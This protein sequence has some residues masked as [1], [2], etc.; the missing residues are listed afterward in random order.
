[1][2]CPTSAWSLNCL[3]F[4]LMTWKL[5]FS[6]FSFLVTLPA[7]AGVP[8]NSNGFTVRIQAEVNGIR[9]SDTHV[10]T[11]ANDKVELHTQ[12]FKDGEAVLLDSV[13]ETYKIEFSWYRLVAEDKIYINPDDVDQLSGMSQFIYSGLSSFVPSK[14]SYKAELF[15]RN[16][17]GLIIPRLSHEAMAPYAE[18]HNGKAAG[19]MRWKVIVKLTPKDSQ[20]GVVRITSPDE[21]RLNLEFSKLN[22]ERTKAVFL[23]ARKGGTGYRSLDE[24]LMFLGLPY[25]WWNGPADSRLGVTCS[26]LVSFAAF[27]KELR[28]HEL[29]KMAG[30]KVT[31]VTEGKFFGIVDGK[32]TLLKFGIHVYPGSVIVFFDGMV[33]RHTAIIGE[34]VGDVRNVLDEKDMMVHAAM[35][36][37]FAKKFSWA[38]IEYAPL[39][40][41]FNEEAVEYGMKIIPL[42]D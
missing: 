7:L 3:V 22:V 16:D 24:G 15:E 9:T 5:L 11:D 1:M 23:L 41:V 18:L 12:L 40:K 31:R 28:T 37:F 8:E 34:D 35:G 6:L 36:G 32:E 25:L 42:K 29:K 17:R 4:T 33:D 39:G 27:K 20:K 21:T 19:S 13:R 14:M 26:Q 38:G 30:I 2:I 10:L